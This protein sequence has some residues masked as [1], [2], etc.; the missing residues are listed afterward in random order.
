VP[1]N[2]RFTGPEALDVVSRSGARALLV[3]DRFLGT[4]RLAAL[5][6]VTVFPLDN[7]SR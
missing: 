5:R 6:A 2:T 7:R 4:D 3:A 1:V